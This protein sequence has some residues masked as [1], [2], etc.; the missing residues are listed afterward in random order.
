MMII[1]EM[2]V[3]GCDRGE[4]PLHPPPLALSNLLAKHHAVHHAQNFSY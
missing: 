2:E 3:G 1:V 4:T